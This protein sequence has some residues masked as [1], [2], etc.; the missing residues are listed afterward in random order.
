MLFIVTTVIILNP[1][2]KEYCMAIEETKRMRFSGEAM[3]IVFKI[4]L[5]ADENC[6]FMSVTSFF[7]LLTP[8]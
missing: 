7:V 1:T 8:Q 3:N 5:V 6:Y 4:D 2:Y